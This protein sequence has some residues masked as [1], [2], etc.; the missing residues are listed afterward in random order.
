[1]NTWTNRTQLVSLVV[2][3]LALDVQAAEPP[4]DASA[5]EAWKI[6][7]PSMT[8]PTSNFL[9]L[10]TATPLVEDLSQAR[11]AWV[12]EDNDLGHGKYSSVIWSGH[13][14]VEEKIGPDAKVH[15]GNW[16]GVVV[17]N[18]RVYGAS[19]RPAGKVFTAP[20]RSNTGYDKS[21][22]PDVPTRFRVEAEDLVICF[23]ASNGKVLWKA[24]EP[25][26][27][28]YSG[29]Q[30]N[31][32]QVAAAVDEGRV[33]AV[34]S[35]GRVFAYDAISGKKLWQNDVG[36][37]YKAREAYRVES[38]E[39]AAAGKIVLP[40]Y[41]DWGSSVVAVNGIVVTADFKGG[42]RGYEA[43]TGKLT[44]TLSN[45]IRD[46][47]TPNI[48]R[49]KGQA[50]L[51]CA[52]TSMFLVDP[53]NGKVAWKVDGLGE[54]PGTLAPG[55]RSVMV[56][57]NSKSKV[58]KENLPGIWGC[59][60]ISPEK[61]EKVWAMAE[62]VP[63]SFAVTSDAR[64]GCSTRIRDGRVLVMTYGTINE[65]GNWGKTDPG[66]IA[67]LD[68]E[69]GAEIVST[70]NGGPYSSVRAFWGNV[71]WLGDR[72]I[73]RTVNGHGRASNIFIDWIV[74]PETISP[75]FGDERR[76][77]DL[78]EYMGSYDIVASTPLVDGRMFERTADGRLACYDLRRSATPETKEVSK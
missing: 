7:W 57:V 48:W 3:S 18:G 34:G 55:E 11:L 61:A 19:Y 52:N 30:R 12:S 65:G 74:T 1:M 50:W 60:R 2:L 62:T 16:A 33:F 20:F 40:K 31:G 39:Q 68:E 26:G 45:C 15:P 32:F 46:T 69:T 63:N 24:V 41:G 10:R 59:Y 76:G 35:T 53:Q 78:I 22:K 72:A 14:A 71:L 13:D 21:P 29:S 70:N 5:E 37:A 8:G 38:V 42:L 77:L 73:V 67:L 44:W 51:V 17:A 47:A 58:G 64:T 75:R 28:I 25:G 56:N 27:Q 36:D 49:H 6:G 4:K 66:R 54:N 23:D 9:P 43:A